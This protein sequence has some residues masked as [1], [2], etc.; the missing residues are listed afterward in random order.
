[1]S[2]IFSTVKT[3]QSAQK[4]QKYKIHSVFIQLGI[5]NFVSILNLALGRTG[6][7]MGCNKTLDHVQTRSKKHPKNAQKSFFHPTQLLQ[8]FVFASFWCTD[9]FFF[10]LYANNAVVF[11]GVGVVSKWRRK[12]ISRPSARW[13]W[14]FPLFSQAIVAAWGELWRQTAELLH[15]HYICTTMQVRIL[16]L[17][18]CTINCFIVIIILF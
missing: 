12:L 3:A 7:P 6:I 13:R 17:L 10:K 14:R 18:L 1:M 4:Q 16:L 11:D 8:S 5:Y 15:G 2:D 9:F